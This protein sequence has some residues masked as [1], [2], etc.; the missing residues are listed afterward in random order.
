MKAPF[1]DPERDGITQTLLSNWL[2][3]R[4]KARYILEGWTPKRVSL[5]MING[6]IGHAVL[7]YV[8]E[9]HRAAELSA[10]PSIQEIKKVVAK[11]EKIWKDE[12]PKASKDAFQDLE[13]S[14]MFAEV[15]LP[16]YFDYWKE[17]YKKIQWESLEGSFK[18]PYV[19]NDGRTTF[20]RGKMDGV[21]K[22]G[23]G[24]SWLFESKFKSLIVEADIV[25]CLALD[26][27]VML[28]LWALETQRK[29]SPAGVYY[30]IVRRP[31]LKLGTPRRLRSSPSGSGRTS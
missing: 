2:E 3:C 20:I 5:S 7:Q 23:A 21:F 12:N 30:N 26:I 31:G 16:I 1:Y 11:V 18:I 9:A 14:L 24:A 19:L 25:D 4:Q 28:Y 13:M 8:Y 27:Q 15:V 22:R 17:D 6:T 29:I 10:V